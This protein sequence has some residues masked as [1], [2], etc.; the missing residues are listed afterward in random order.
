ML[1][2]SV[3]YRALLDIEVKGLT[4]LLETLELWVCHLPANPNRC[5]S[6]IRY[7]L[8]VRAGYNQ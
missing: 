3:W 1:L 4:R 5:R 7:L 8:S 2:A 6:E